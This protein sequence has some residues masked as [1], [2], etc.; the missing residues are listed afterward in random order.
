MYARSG[1][2]RHRNRHDTCATRAVILDYW[3]PGMN[4]AA[5]AIVLHRREEQKQDQPQ[6]LTL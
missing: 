4:G 2:R 1:H 3:V 6:E 5:I